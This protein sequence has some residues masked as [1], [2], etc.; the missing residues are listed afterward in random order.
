MPY[1]AV[2]LA[3]FLIPALWG[4]TSIGNALSASD[5]VVCPGE[6]LR[7]GEEHPGPM[8]PEDTECSVL[9]GS[10]AVANRTYTQQQRVQDL[11][12]RRDA[13]NGGLLL[14]YGTAGSLVSW[15]A[16]RPRAPRD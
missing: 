11:Q 6:N 3:L 13:V 5:E 7:G 2:L 1:R 8:R 15:F 16:A 10:T 9:D 14:A 12:R 4:A